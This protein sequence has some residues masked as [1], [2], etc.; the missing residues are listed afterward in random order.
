MSAF[1]LKRYSGISA[2]LLRQRSGISAFLF[3]SGLYF[4]AIDAYSL[5]V[6][7]Q[8][9]VFIKTFETPSSETKSIERTHN[10]NR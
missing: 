3:W 7:Q 1:P 2:C 4:C 5:A 6:V 8:R 10:V 9:C